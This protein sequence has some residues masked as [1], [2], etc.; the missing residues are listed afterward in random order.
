MADYT[1]MF[2]SN[3]KQEFTLLRGICSLL[4]LQ[5]LF[6]RLNPLVN[7]LEGPALEGRW[8]EQRSEVKSVVVGRV[9]FPG[10][11]STS[12]TQYKIQDARLHM[13]SWCCHSLFVTT[14]C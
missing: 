2:V 5:S 9:I 12:S 6:Q 7:L 3:T 1:V 14:S 10:Q 4:L 11:K 8:V 13:N